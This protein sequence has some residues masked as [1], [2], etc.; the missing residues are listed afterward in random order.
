MN[1]SM[2]GSGERALQILLAVRMFHGLTCFLLTPVEKLNPSNVTAALSPEFEAV[3]TA[4]FNGEEVPENFNTLKYDDQSVPESSTKPA[5]QVVKYKIDYGTFWGRVVQT[6]W[7]SK[8]AL[9]TFLIDVIMANEMEQSC[10]S[11]G[12]NCEVKI[13]RHP[14]YQ[15]HRDYIE[16][17]DGQETQTQLGNPPAL[18]EDRDD[19]ADND[20]TQVNPSELLTPSEFPDLAHPPIN[21]QSSGQSEKAKKRKKNAPR[22]TKSATQDSTSEDN[23]ALATASVEDME[24]G[25]GSAMESNPSSRPEPSSILCES[26]ALS[27]PTKNPHAELADTTN[28]DGD[29]SLVEFKAKASQRKCKRG[30]RAPVRNDHFQS[31]STKPNRGQQSQPRT[32]STQVRF[33]PGVDFPC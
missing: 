32:N 26:E 16:G 2:L 21:P 31:A 7:L 14:H 11:W 17:L 15:R 5:A 18:G 22:K 24:T 13:V 3:A 10:R 30:S 19:D 27:T 25:Q 1:Q 20:N 23:S 28:E 6:G 12:N 33:I 4:F 9:S 8:P 29:W